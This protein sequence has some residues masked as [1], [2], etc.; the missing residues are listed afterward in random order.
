MREIFEILGVLN[1]TASAAVLVAIFRQRL[2]KMYRAFIVYLIFD[3]SANA[4]SL[5]LGINSRRHFDL[6]IFSLPV[7]A[8]LRY[9]TLRELYCEIY[10]N[11]PGLALLARR[12]LSRSVIVAC[13]FAV[14]V[15]PATAPRWSDPAFQ[16]WQFPYEEAYRFCVTGLCAYLLLMRRFLQKL[17]V[18]LPRNTRL[19][20][21][22]QMINLAAYSLANVVLLL[23][24]NRNITYICGTGLLCISVSTSL[25]LATLLRARLSGLI[26]STDRANEPAITASTENMTVLVKLLGDAAERKMRILFRVNAGTSES[27]SIAERN[28]D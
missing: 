9:F 19:L 14:L 22:F 20:I 27:T 13:L 23:N 28:G 10:Q 24:A 12:T 25:A 26:E 4:A 21:G 18:P 8:A 5:L 11:F 6:F 7:Y 16:C 17:S 3:V 15:I 2:H 1:S